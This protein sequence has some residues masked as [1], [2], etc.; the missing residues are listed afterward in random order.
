[1]LAVEAR[2]KRHRAA[3]GGRNLGGAVGPCEPVKTRLW[4]T[5]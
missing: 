1:M 3:R 2:N 5:G 4:T